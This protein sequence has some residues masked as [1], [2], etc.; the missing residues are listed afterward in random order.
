MTDT[1]TEYQR[2]IGVGERQ[3]QDRKVTDM[4]TTL[5]EPVP[6]EDGGRAGWHIKHKSGR[7]DAIVETRQIRTEHSKKE[8]AQLFCKSD[9]DLRA[10]GLTTKE[11][12]IG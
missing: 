2:H 7:Q 9:A 1:R 5:R 10:A 4:K 11:A 6:H 12:G 3:P 8:F